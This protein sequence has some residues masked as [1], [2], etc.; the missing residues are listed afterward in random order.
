MLR[1]IRRLVLTIVN[2]RKVFSL[3]T[4]AVIF[5]SF[6]GAVFVNAG[7][8]RRRGAQPGPNKGSVFCIVK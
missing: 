2:R 3:V 4:I 1:Y 6:D 8:Y 7:G 5:A